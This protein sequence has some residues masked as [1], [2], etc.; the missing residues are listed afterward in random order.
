MHGG[1]TCITEIKILQI[2]NP[3][4]GRWDLQE[5]A[6]V[7]TQRITALVADNDRLA[8]KSINVRRCAIS[9]SYLFEVIAAPHII[10]AD[11][12]SELGVDQPGEQ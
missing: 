11:Q 1:I 9:T 6:C 5:A 3:S 10:I 2:R 8:E 12:G 4:G 7:S